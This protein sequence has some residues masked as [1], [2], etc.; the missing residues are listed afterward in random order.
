MWLNRN[1]RKLLMI[2]YFKITSEKNVEDISEEKWFRL[3]DLARVLKSHNL[4]KAT[5]KLP[6]Y[7]VGDAIQSDNKK[8]NIDAQVNVATNRLEK[9]GLIKIRYGPEGSNSEWRGISLTIDGYDLGEKYSHWFTRTGLLYQEY[10]KH[11]VCVII[12]FLLG[13]LTTLIVSWLSR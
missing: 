5:K 4:K 3:S 9:R 2:Y 10:K 8:R 11:W 6:N 1:E 12:A 7:C 13:I